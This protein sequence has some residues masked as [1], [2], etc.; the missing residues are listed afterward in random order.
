MVIELDEPE[1]IARAG[2]RRRRPSTL[3]TGVRRARRPG[4]R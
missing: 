3:L 4:S 1:V 2:R